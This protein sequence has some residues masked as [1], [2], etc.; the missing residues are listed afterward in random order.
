MALPHLSLLLPLVWQMCWL[1]LTGVCGQPVTAGAAEQEWVARLVSPSQDTGPWVLCTYTC[2]PLFLLAQAWGLA[3]ALFAPLVFGPSCLRLLQ[4]KLRDPA[5]FSPFRREKLSVCAVAAG[6]QGFENRTVLLHEHRQG[7]WY[8]GM[9]KKFHPF[10][11][12]C[13]HSGQNYTKP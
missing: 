10:H 12:W 8:A 4:K 2:C 6:G 3:A 1:C 13:L 11:G 5:D 9:L 7:R